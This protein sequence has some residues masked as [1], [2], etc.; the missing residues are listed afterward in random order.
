MCGPVQAPVVSICLVAPPYPPSTTALL[1]PLESLPASNVPDF[2]SKFAPPTSI[3][4][5][6]S[7]I[8]SGAGLQ[9]LALLPFSS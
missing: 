6:A 2:N 9:S 7:L 3:L 4:S 5:I 8:S 1:L